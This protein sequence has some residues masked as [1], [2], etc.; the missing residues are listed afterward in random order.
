MNAK[1]NAG[2]KPGQAIVLEPGEQAPPVQM[3]EAVTGLDGLELNDRKRERIT[4]IRA[5]EAA[6]LELLAF[7]APNGNATRELN[8][9]KTKLEEAAMWAIKGVV[10]Q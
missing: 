2:V 8:F 1:T 7:I 9:A 5:A 3:G 10:A 4:E 6:F